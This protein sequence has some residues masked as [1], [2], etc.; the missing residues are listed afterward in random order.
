MSRISLMV[1]L[2]AVVACP[3]ADVVAAPGSHAAKTHLPKKV[4]PLTRYVLGAG[5]GDRT[6]MLPG[7]S[8]R[9]K[10]PPR[11]RGSIRFKSTPA[12]DVLVRLRELGVR[13]SER[14]TDVSHLGRIYPASIPS[15]A[16]ELLSSFGEIVRLEIV[17]PG[18]APE[19]VENYPKMTEALPA[20]L[21]TDDNGIPTTGKGVTIGAIDAWLDIFHPSF[22][23]ADGGLFDW[24]DVNDDGVFQAG[25]DGIDMNQDGTVNS[26]EVLRLMKGVVVWTE[27][28]GM[29]YE[30]KVENNGDEFVPDMDWLWLDVNGSGKR[31]AGTKAGFVE[32]SPTFGEQIFVA[33]DIDGSGTFDSGEKLV[34]LRTSKIRKIYLPHTGEVFTRGENLIEYPRLTAVSS[35]ATMTIGVVAGS[36]HGY[37]RLHGV[38]PDAEILLADMENGGGMGTGNPD[39]YGSPYIDALAWMAENG[40]DVVMHEYGWPLMQFGDGSSDVELAIDETTASGLVNC[41]AT[42]NYAGYPMH[43]QAKVPAGGSV[44]FPVEIK[45][46]GGDYAA[47]VLYATLRWR[48]PSGD[49]AITMVDEAK[50]EFVF[51]PEEADGNLDDL[52]VWTSGIEVSDRGTYMANLV[53]YQDGYGQLLSEGEYALKVHNSGDSP[54]TVDLFV[55]D[56][57][58]YFVG[59]ALKEHNS[60]A[61]TIS[62]PATADTAISVGAYRA[63][64]DS[65]YGQVEVGDLTYYS[66]QGPRI[67]GERGIDIVAPS[68]ALAAWHDPT[69]TH[70]P[71]WSY[72][73]GTSGSLPQVTGAV[74]VM[75]QVSPDLSPEQVKQRLAGSGLSDTF[76]GAL[77]N[78]IWGQGKLSV[79]GAAYD[80][81]PTDN[82]RPM[83]QVTHPVEVRLGEPFTLDAG[84]STDDGSLEE[85]R[86]RWD[87]GYNGKYE[88]PFSDDLA[89]HIDALN[90]PGL[91]RAVAQ[92]RDGLGYT[93]RTLAMVTV[94]DEQYV[95]SPEPSVRKEDIRTDTDIQKEGDMLN[96]GDTL[97]QT[98]DDG[99]TTKSGGCSTSSSPGVSWPLWLLLGGLALLVTRRRGPW[100]RESCIPVLLLVALGAGC[101]GGGSSADTLATD[102]PATPKDT[103]VA[104]TS[105]VPDQTVIPDVI[106]PED[107]VAPQDSWPID[108][109]LDDSKTDT[110]VVDLAQQDSKDDTPTDS[111]LSDTYFEDIQ[112]SDEAAEAVEPE[113]VPADIGGTDPEPIPGVPWKF[114]VALDH[115]M[116]KRQVQGGVVTV[117]CVAMDGSMVVLADPPD[118]VISTDDPNAQL[119]GAKFSFPDEGDFTISCHS[120]GLD[121]EGHAGVAVISDAIDQQFIDVGNRMGKLHLTLSHLVKAAQQEDDGAIAQACTAL[122]ALAEDCNPDFVGKSD[123]LIPFPGG[124][125]SVQ[126]MQDNGIEAKPDDAAFG[127][128]LDDVIG[129]L[130]AVNASLALIQQDPTEDHIDQYLAAAQELADV[131][132]EFSE[133]DPSPLAL[134]ANMGKLDQ[135]SGPALDESV[136]QTAATLEV[137]F[138]GDRTTMIEMAIVV[139]VKAILATIPSYTQVL[140]TIGKRLTQMAIMWA[141]NDLMNYNLELPDSPPVLESVHGPTFGAIV[142]G[143]EWYA[144][145]KGFHED[146]KFTIFIFIAPEYA[147]LIN[148]AIWGIIDLL[149]SI[150]DLTGDDNPF[151]QIQTAKGLV[152]GIK[153]WAEGISKIGNAEHIAIQPVMIGG[154][155]PQ[156]LQFPPL[157]TGVN[158]SWMMQNG[159]MIPVNL[160]SGGGK[161]KQVLVMQEPAAACN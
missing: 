56:Q 61:G 11:V 135:L 15:S 22:F 114:V 87:F 128:K 131:V 60:K 103:L 97:T 7:D 27:G 93:D 55:A 39:E 81:P 26:G 144:T 79:F 99:P 122:K 126:K 5:R 152:D 52:L 138:D 30:E 125:P 92:V 42:H 24:I 13:F 154:Q 36:N 140:I 150:K 58:G 4:S 8:A 1:V 59:G 151:S 155:Y 77:P 110:T 70:Y 119:D 72:A 71:Q 49:L 28:S 75:L 41:T 6:V 14:G 158:C 124:Y 16:L 148:D 127:A 19:F 113:L 133:L 129:K 32:N 46:Y 53:A 121:I 94:I 51:P 45:G 10:V 85:L 109:A 104:D 98:P 12:A 29:G 74:A 89:V 68:D 136:R 57:Y 40:A 132:A 142:P 146:P 153:E 91:F 33:D 145:G 73:S 84:A 134:M 21:T 35:H 18:P 161:S 69:G 107:L 149:S 34:A 20:W 88:I 50:N 43:G 38:A 111:M 115:S 90:Q 76:T 130:G 118:T 83:A 65:W 105:V 64:V 116:I 17:P 54:Q 112:A 147:A 82:A 67:D 102:L 139:G 23:R 2:L 31:E 95:P 159:V 9:R 44:S 108:I 100:T 141:I 106:L 143:M 96:Q 66:G 48:E 156:T 80:G 86:V 137:V 160:L 25:V 47:Y 101:S 78:H 62:H 120:A 37:Q 3:P 123:L 117:D 157:Q 63:N